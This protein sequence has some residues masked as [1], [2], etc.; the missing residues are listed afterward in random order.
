VITELSGVINAAPT[1][2]TGVPAKRCFM[3]SL[4]ATSKPQL[5][6]RRRSTLTPRAASSG[7]QAP[8]DPSFAQLP[9]PSASTVAP[10]PTFSSPAGVA[11]RSAPSAAQPVQP[12]ACVEAH[13]GGA[14]PVQPGTQQRRGLHLLRENAAGTAD[15]GVDA[16]PLRPVAQ[17]LRTEFVEPAA[18]FGAAR[19][20]A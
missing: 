17:L 14:Q 20:S 10:A 7:T 12:M 11:K 2:F 6:G 13:A 1:F 18:D 15:E 9:P 5:A 19:R 4:Q 3:C 16:E 8:S